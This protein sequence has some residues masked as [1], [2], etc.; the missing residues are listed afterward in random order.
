ML[1]SRTVPLTGQFA[2]LS[3]QVAGLCTQHPI[4]RA[5][6]TAAY[7][8]AKRQAV[9]DPYQSKLEVD[10]F[11]TRAQLVGSAENG[12]PPPVVL[13][14]R[15]PCEFHKGHIPGAINVPLFD[16]AERVIVGTLYKKEGHDIAVRRGIKLMDA[17]IRETI[18][19]ID[20]LKVQPGDELLIYCKRGGMRS[21]G[22]AWLLSQAEVN[23]HTLA[24]GYQGFR[25]WVKDTWSMDRSLV[26]LGGKTGS[27]KTDVLVALRESFG[28]QVVDLEGEANH[29]GSTFGSLGLPPQPTSGMY[30]NNLALQWR[31]FS[32]A[33]PVF[34][35][36]EGRHV[37]SATVP[38]GLWARMRS[39]ETRLLR[40]EIPQ[41]ARVQR[42]VGEYGVYP[43][44][45]LADC[46]R[47]VSK[48]LGTD[49][50]EEALALLQQQPPGLAEITSMLLSSYYDA[51]YEKQAA[52]QA[53]EKG[54]P[55]EH[56]VC[57]TGGALA[58]AQL[59][60]EAIEDQALGR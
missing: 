29:R 45:R 17:K 53:I 7:E 56:L 59:V 23:V 13:D 57:S 9:A 58:N 41:V 43:R 15:A 19:Q 28:C 37:G 8:C 5:I 11:L 4:A 38:C 31:S 1:F 32:S 26:L 36:N 46:I 21:G 35:E 16:D 3:Q 33:A 52:K 54:V 50:T 48:R 40:L 51:S 39:A 2:K 22:M 55:D 47:K 25:T 6:D 10:P 44:D 18:D 60:L 42:L 20:R 12:L 14:V 24:G 34:I 49:K 27:G 30:E